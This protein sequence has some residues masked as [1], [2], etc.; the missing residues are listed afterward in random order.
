MVERG[1]AGIYRRLEQPPDTGDFGDAGIS[2][3]LLETEP[4]SPYLSAS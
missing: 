1:D 3:G 4:G 2:G